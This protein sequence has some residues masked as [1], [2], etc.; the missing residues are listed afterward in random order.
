MTAPWAPPELDAG[1][2][3]GRWGWAELRGRWRLLG[4]LT[5]AA[6]AGGLFSA[7]GEAEAAAAEAGGGSSPAEDGAGGAGG[8]KKGKGGAE[9]GV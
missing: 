3:L 5:G 2:Q 8:P 1:D 7:E 4:D 9:E 6:V